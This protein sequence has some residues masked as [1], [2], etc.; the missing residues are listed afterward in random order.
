MTKFNPEEPEDIIEFDV[1][2]GDYVPEQD[3]ESSVQSAATIGNIVL[4]CA[5]FSTA[6]FLIWKFLPDELLP[7]AKTSLIGFSVVTLVRLFLSLFLPVVFFAQRY[8]IQD[9]RIIGRYPGIG[10]ALLSF[11]IG[12]PVSL[13]VV[14]VH[15]LLVHFFAAKGISPA[16]PAFFYSSKDISM[17]SRLLA[18]AAAF[19]IPILLQELFFR[20]LLFSVWPRS[21][22]VSPKILLS[23]LLFALFMQNPVDFIPLFFLGV[24]LAYV[25]HSTDN[26]LCPVIT[27]VSML[28]TYFVFSSLLPYQDYI[29][30]NV[31]NDADSVYLY[32][33]AAALV[34]SLLAFLPVLAQLRHLSH[35]SARISEFQDEQEEE[36]LH[37]QF[38]WSFWLGLILF[39]ASWVLLLDI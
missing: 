37:G 7:F 11:M 31:T 29:A 5:A 13:I 22:A 17:E 14:A 33:A 36:S 8:R 23:G 38:G 12:C 24:I 15:N 6:V 39:A 2:S 21:T 32:T 28:L 3:E 18:L 4:F 10:A 34:M 25:R 27:Q 26:F 35:E 9:A 19:L 16:L 30:V 1:T 20:G